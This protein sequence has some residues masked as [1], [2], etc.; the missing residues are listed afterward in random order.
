MLGFKR[1]LLEKV[2]TGDKTNTRRIAKD[3][4]RLVI[5]PDGTKTVYDKRGRIKWQTGR[6]YGCWPGRG[7]RAECRYKLNDLR[8]EIAGEISEADA[9]A[10][11]FANREAFLN[12]WDEINGKNQRQKRVWVHVWN[13]VFDVKPEP[14]AAAPMTRETFEEYEP[15]LTGQA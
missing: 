12:A 6:D 11:G 4:E 1:F 13:E 5:D 10:E 3:G 9:R 2:K 14:V 8:E 7:L 15:F